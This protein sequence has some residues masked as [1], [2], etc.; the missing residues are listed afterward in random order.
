MDVSVHTP[1]M[2]LVILKNAGGSSIT[3]RLEVK[4]PT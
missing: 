1:E 2:I 4:H 3:E